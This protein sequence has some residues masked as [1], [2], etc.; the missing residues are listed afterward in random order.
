MTQWVW[1][2]HHAPGKALS[3]HSVGAQNSPQP[4]A[5]FPTFKDGPILIRDLLESRIN[6][7]V[8]QAAG[9]LF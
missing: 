7:T 6:S 5:P 8:E 1:L 2:V 9:N 3:V 4:A